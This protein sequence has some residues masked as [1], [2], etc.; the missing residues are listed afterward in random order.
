MIEG[1]IIK[2]IER[3][4]DARGWLAEI[5]RSDETDYRPSMSYISLTNPGSVRGPHE[6]AM[7]SDCF[8][9]VGPGIFEVH[10]WDRRETS[11]TKDEYQKIIAG[12]GSPTMIIVPP[13]IVHGYKCI[14]AEPAL[15]INLPDRLFRGEGKNEESD[16]IRWE[17]DPASPYKIN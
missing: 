9:F 1:V 2:K 12:E 17:A 11:A 6:H 7:Q 5:Y 15:S 16:E 3:F 8:I 10:L 4:E 14:S 13:G